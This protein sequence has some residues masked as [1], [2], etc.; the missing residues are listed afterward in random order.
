MGMKN[1]CEINVPLRKAQYENAF[2]KIV[3]RLQI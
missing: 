2:L 1:S 3:Q